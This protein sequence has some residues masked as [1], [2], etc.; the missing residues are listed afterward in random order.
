MA[1]YTKKRKYNGRKQAFDSHTNTWV[2]LT[3][4]TYSDTVEVEA[5]AGGWISDS[6]SSSSSY[7]SSS[8]DSGSSYSSSSS[9]YDSGSSSS[10][11]SDF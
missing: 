2:Y 10:S 4:L 8:Y 11:G 6:S 3:N 5:L 7:S 9:S 1:R